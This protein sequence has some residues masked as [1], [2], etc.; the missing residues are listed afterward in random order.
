[1]RRQSGGVGGETTAPCCSPRPSCCPLPYVSKKEAKKI[2]ESKSFTKSSTKNQ[3]VSQRFTILGRSSTILGQKPQTHFSFLQKL[4]SVSKEPL[5]HNDLV[6][7]PNQDT[8]CLKT[9][10]NL[11]FYQSYTLSGVSHFRFGA[12]QV[13]RL[14]FPAVLFPRNVHSTFFRF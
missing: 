1:M 6:F 2:E 7:F 5:L 4:P 12:R 3:F 9:H 10:S 14:D 13:T 11:G 8:Q